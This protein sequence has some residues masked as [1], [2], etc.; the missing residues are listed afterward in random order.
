MLLMYFVLHCLY[1]V[2]KNITT[3]NTADG[4]STRQDTSNYQRNLIV[5]EYSGFGTQRVKD[6]TVPIL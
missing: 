3:I 4:F 1:S 2:E 5:P 6:E